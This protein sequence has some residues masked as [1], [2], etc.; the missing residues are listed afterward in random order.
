MA[1]LIVLF[2]IGYT[3]TYS[4]YTNFISEG[5]GLTFF[6]ALGV[7]PSNLTS[8]IVVPTVDFNVQPQ[9]ATFM[10]QTQAI[11]SSSPSNVAAV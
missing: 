7:Q 11:Q 6:E 2:L 10:S 1:I 5:K 4:G 9:T 3:M 8:K